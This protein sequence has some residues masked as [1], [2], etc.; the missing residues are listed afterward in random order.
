MNYIANYRRGVANFALFVTIKNNSLYN[1]SI[2]SNLIKLIKLIGARLFT[3]PQQRVIVG[4]RALGCW[5]LI[6]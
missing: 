5:I 4:R 1:Y 3:L 2:K 6:L